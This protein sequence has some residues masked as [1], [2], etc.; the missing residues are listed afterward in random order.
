MNMK[1]RI[2]VTIYGLLSILNLVS[3]LLIIVP[4]HRYD[5]SPECITRRGY[6][7]APEGFDELHPIFQGLIY[8]NVLLSDAIIIASIV[9]LIG[10]G[11]QTGC[12]TVQEAL[13]FL[14]AIIGLMIVYGCLTEKSH[15]I[16]FI[17][18]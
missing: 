3:A 1:K 14:L 5:F 15:M 12:R 8:V 17:L 18:D 7:V 9:I 6:G 13:P 2:R 11:W 16:E 10:M 4:F